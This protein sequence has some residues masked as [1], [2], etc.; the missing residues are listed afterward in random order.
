MSGNFIY[1]HH[2]EPRVKLFS[3]REESFHI[4]LK[5]IDVSRTTHTNLDVMQE[6]RIDDSWNIDGSREFSDSCTSF[7][8]FILLEEKT[9]RWI[10]VVR[11]ETDKTAS[12]IQARSLMART[13]DEIGEEMHSWKRGKSGH[14]KSQNSIMPE[15]YEE[16]ISLTLR[17]RSEKRPSRML[18][19]NG[20]HQWLPLCLA[21]QTRTVS[22][23]WL[24]V[25][26]KR[27]IH[28]TACGK[29]FTESSWRPYC[30]K[31]GQ[32]TAALQFGTQIYSYTSSHENSRSRG[33]SW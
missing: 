6:R 24:V 22:M 1:R 17:T 23:V 2:A 26:P 10:Y 4:P 25:N 7:N 33:S 15:N 28:K 16:F 18:A 20:K 29:I 13:L 3:P 14:T 19:R 31:G 9:S 12:D 21:R 30:R 11:G 8:Q 27:W 32:F 5:Y